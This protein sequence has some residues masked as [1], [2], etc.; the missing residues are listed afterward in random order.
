MK[1]K[2]LHLYYDLMNLYGEYGNIKIL[3][4][5]L[6]DN[7][8]EVEVDKKTIGDNYNL[9]DY[10]FIYI[11]CGIESN[12]MVALN[13]LLKHKEE[14]KKYIDDNKYALFT[15][16]SYEML[17]KTIDGKDGLN[18]LD[19]TVERLKDRKVEDVIMSS[20]SFENEFVGFINKISNIKNNNNHL[21]EVKFGI[22]ENE[23]NKYEGI[24]F[25]NL[26]GT[27]IIG[28]ILVRNPFF[29]NYLMTGICKSK[30][31]SF[32]KEFKKYENEEEGYKLVLNELKN[33]Q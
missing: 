19:F 5:H 7:G 2:I 33:R 26:Y 32:D 12:E 15:G 9:N 14:L 1:I 23:D 29:L 31:A 28:P 27:Y 20:S 10:D 13:D 22:G 11:G 8:I 21:F 30:D 6:K 17:G 18:I 4:H 3:E 25:N 16:N 24:K